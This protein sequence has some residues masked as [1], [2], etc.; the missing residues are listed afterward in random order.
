MSKKSIKEMYSDILLWGT[1]PISRGKRY[2]LTNLQESVLRKLI[3]YDR[4]NKFINYS[5]ETI[6]YHMYRDGAV[7]YLKK[8]I[9]ELNK[10][11]YISISNKKHYKDGEFK[12]SRTIM[13]DWDFIESIVPDLPKVK[14]KLEIEELIMISDDE[15]EIESQNE[16]EDLENSI[17]LDD[18]IDLYN[19]LPRIGFSSEDT[20]Y[21]IDALN[22]SLP[23]FRDFIKCIKDLIKESNYKDYTGP[24]ITPE[25]KSNLDY[26]QYKLR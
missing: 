25:I 1:S 19:V 24:K 15:I 12:T 22:D 9:P 18:E 7:D 3:H 23:I 13:I 21:I 6:S 14:S 11:G 16:L 4:S 8:I 26:I 5:N 2:H 17:R 10:L 20:I